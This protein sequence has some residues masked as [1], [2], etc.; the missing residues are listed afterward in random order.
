M[1]SDDN[2]TD[3]T[4]DTD[5]QPS[6]R[7][8]ESAR[9]SIVSRIVENLGEIVDGFIGAAKTGSATHMKLVFDLLKTP[10][11]PEQPTQPQNSALDILDEL[12]RRAGLDP[13]P[14]GSPE[15]ESI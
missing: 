10:P 1:Q 3:N 7:Q 12:R 8:I 6:S 11:T 4:T 9:S 5:T 2:T 13:T 14:A 15:A